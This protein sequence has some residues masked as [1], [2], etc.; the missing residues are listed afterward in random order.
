MIVT[1]FEIDQ[2]RGR[3]SL[4]LLDLGN[5][6]NVTLVSN[7]LD[8]AAM[9]SVVPYVLYGTVA[10][11]H[12]RWCDSMATDASLA[13]QCDHGVFR[14][15]RLVDDPGE[16]LIRS[17]D[18]LAAEADYLETLVDGVGSRTF[19][20]TF[21]LNARS[22][23]RRLER[24]RRNVADQIERMAESLRDASPQVES[25]VPRVS[26][27]PLREMDSCV[28]Q[29]K[30]TIGSH[31]EHEREQARWL[32]ELPTRDQ[33]NTELKRIEHEL[34]DAQ[35]K[36]QRAIREVEETR[37]AMNFHQLRA[38]L[39]SVEKDLATL[40]EAPT[41]GPLAQHSSPA[42]NEIDD[43]LRR[44]RERLEQL[45]EQRR[46]ANEALIDDEHRVKIRRMFPRIEGVLLQEK[47]IATEEQS[48]EQLADTIRD[49][50]SRIETDRVAAETRAAELAADSERAAQSL[51]DIDRL[52]ALVKEAKRRY[53]SSQRPEPQDSHDDISVPQPQPTRSNRPETQALADAELA[54]SQL[55]E[56]MGVDRTLSDLMSN[57]DALQAQL[58]RIYGQH[59]P[60]L[61]M[62][63]MLGIP[64]ALG[65][66]MILNGYYRHDPANLNL[67]GLGSLVLIVTSF[68]KLST[69]NVNGDQLLQIRNQLN[70]LS[71]EIEEAE[72]FR[73][74]FDREWPDTVRPWQDQLVHAERQL[75]SLRRNIDDG[76]TAVH[77]D[78]TGEFED[79]DES[80]PRENVDA[81][82]R[83]RRSSEA[84]HRYRDAT[85]RWEALLASIG[86][87]TNLTPPQ[88]RLA[89]EQKVLEAQSASPLSSSALEFQLRQ[90]RNDLER[91]RNGLAE[92]LGQS[93]QIV[94]ELG[95]SLKG[96]TS[97]E[98][99][100]ILRETV[101]EHHETE[102]DHQE[103]GLRLQLLKDREE[104]LQTY[105]HGLDHKRRELQRDI[106]KKSDVE[107]A[108]QQ[109]R[110]ERER[111]LEQEREQ[112]L[113]HIEA[114]SSRETDD[115]VVSVLS[116]LSD[117]QLQARIN[118]LRN[119][120][121]DMQAVV[122]TLVDRRARV[123]ERLK[124]IDELE[125]QTAHDA[126]WNDVVVTTRDLSK[127]WYAASRE[128][129]RQTKALAAQLKQAENYK[130]LEL[131]AEHCSL[132]ADYAVDLSFDDNGSMRFLSK[133]GKW[134]SL[135]RLN[136]HRLGQL[137]VGLWLAQIQEF[138][139]RGVKM[140]VIMDDALL[141]APRHR[142][143]LAALLRDFAA[144][145]HQLLLTTSRKKHA[146]VFAALEVPIA[147]L[148]DRE[149]VVARDEATV[150]EFGP[151]A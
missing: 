74:E 146:D 48:I 23:R 70:E 122:V 40:R 97:G 125:K 150:D 109:V 44:S 67:M 78:A 117:D 89:V 121:N 137:F 145:G 104:R 76:S 69:D 54:V 106:E 21:T 53:Y 127:R 103:T 62:L 1:E 149:T 124:Q 60:P 8:K 144:R 4:R 115:A 71:L 139:D 94:Q 65:A 2:F 140:P 46:E 105:R 123:H 14:L 142:T 6:L 26:L 151:S 30:R 130:Y 90:L 41:V 129:H 120:Q 15:D 11:D 39:A 42:L 16:V 147:D 36:E 51:G 12:P 72:S 148:A 31:A 32:A 43:R 57:H 99:M 88:A 38:R 63:M 131:A 59:L 25:V 111:L 49:L 5:G 33:L 18:G 84:R 50:E 93:R 118:D 29:L 143:R 119:R 108:K 87:A 110:R 10:T 19:F 126:M 64:F 107:R 86:L 22:L 28:S 91:R 138:A 116:E 98:Q 96:L 85:A 37:L 83:Q 112:L 3:N 135:R 101:Q 34:T 113:H 79:Y 141:L 81:R 20:S 92:I 27:K 128:Q 17:P 35:S 82:L 136:P 47:F 80:R 7:N 9:L 77:D 45:H 66:A 68:I 73:D 95:Y 102:R 52:G 132:L 24:N 75:Q 13:I 58:R 134:Q 56:R 100:E 114:S 133:T 55:R 61:P